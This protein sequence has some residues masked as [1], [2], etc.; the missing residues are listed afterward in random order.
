M[1]NEFSGVSRLIQTSR[2]YLVS[3]LFRL[4]IE[5]FRIKGCIIICNDIDFHPAALLSQLYVR[6]LNPLSCTC[7]HVKCPL[8]PQLKPIYTFS[9]RRATR[10]HKMWS[11]S[12]AHVH[13]GLHRPSVFSKTCVSMSVYADTQ[14][15]ITEPRAWPISSLICIYMAKKS[16]FSRKNLAGKSGFSDPLP[17]YGN[18][19][20]RLHDI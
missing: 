1:W 3:V 6:W 14:H 12:S 13:E 17:N 5:L 10:V 8:E 18:Q 19:V 11:S 20:S 9:I 4:W 16:A 7:S 2:G 15:S